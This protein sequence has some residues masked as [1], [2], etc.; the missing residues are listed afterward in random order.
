MPSMYDRL[1][2]ESTLF[3]LFESEAYSDTVKSLIL[4]QND[5]AAKILSIKGDTWTKRRLAEVKKLVDELVRQ[6]YA[7]TLPALQV[8]LEAVAGITAQNV[9]AAS[10][11]SVPVSTI[12]EITADSYLVQG[13]TSKEL[14]KAAEDNH[15]RQLKV[16]IGAGVS[17]GKPAQAIISDLM[18]KNSQLSKGQLR[19]AVFT[20]I[21]EARAKTRHD[22]YVMMEKSGVITGYQYI[23]T[24]DSRTTPYCQQHDHRIYRNK[25]IKDIQSEINVHFHCRS[26]FVP[27]TESTRKTERA[28]T[29]GPVQDESYSKWFRRQPD[30][31]KLTTLGRKKYDAYKAG[32]YKVHGLPDVKGRN[33][34][35]KTIGGALK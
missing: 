3:E 33:L 34:S 16:I 1:L 8:E 28:S 10:F 5:I 23:A 7:G 11:T 4:A 22:S 24:L 9:L 27:I 30:G 21:T 13:Y 26:V 15:A 17:Q 35:L 20:T 2:Q 18:L 32:D 31:F 14:F 29:F 6:A 12:S 25:S 19:N